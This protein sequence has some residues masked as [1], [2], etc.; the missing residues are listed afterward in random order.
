MRQTLGA[1]LLAADRAA[2]AEVVYQEDLVQYPKS[3]VIRCVSEFV[4]LDESP[5][6]SVKQGH[7]IKEHKYVVLTQQ[8]N[9]AGR[10]RCLSLEIIDDRQRPARALQFVRGLVADLQNRFH[11]RLARLIGGM[12]PGS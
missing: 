4:S 8:E 12:M 6:S 5:L 3:R 1:R 9:P 7:S 2:E 11:D 10:Q